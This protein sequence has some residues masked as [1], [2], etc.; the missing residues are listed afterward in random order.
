MKEA[1]F[2]SKKEKNVQC[3]LCPRRCFIKNGERGFCGVRENRDGKLYSLVFGK[4]I[5]V[6][7]DP[8]E[9]KPFF[10]FFPGTKTL[11][12]ATVGCNL[13]CLHCQN[14][15]I[16]QPENKEIQGEDLQPD[17]II[18][19]AKNY[20]GI[21]WTYTEPTV[22][23]EYFYETA[24]LCNKISPGL[25][26]TWVSNGFTNPEPI[27]KAA[28]FLDAVNVDYKGDDKF[29]R[30]VCSA[31]LEPVQDAIKLYKK[32]GVWVELT[33]LII[34]GHNDKDSIIKEMCSWILDNLGPDVPLHFSAYFPYHKMS[35]PQT[36]FQTLE[37]AYEIAKNAGINYVYIGNVRNEKENTYCHNCN[38]LLIERFGFS[39]IK[40][41]IKKKGK[42][43]HCPNCNTKI[44]I[45]LK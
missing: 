19:I 26:Q 15:D 38:K 35:A 3:E 37:H 4:A 42:N 31:W 23:Y 11:S 25:Y 16:S 6:A 28:E 9:K 45:F 2:Y 5:A 39:V 8:I 21:S 27:K 20:S 36:P 30:N 12:I 41:D 13:K 17:E 1:M 10:H 32:L 44:P 14:F 40:I 22:F 29:Y 18:K 43:Y 34:P 24:K 7:V 33:N